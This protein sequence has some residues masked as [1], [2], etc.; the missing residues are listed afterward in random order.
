MLGRRER[1]TGSDSETGEEVVDDGPER[2]LPLELDVHRSVKCEGGDDGE[3]EGRDNIDF[4]VEGAEGDR[5][6][7]L[8]LGEDLADVVV[9]DYG[10]VDGGVI[11]FGIG[12]NEGIVRVGL[13]RLSAGLREVGVSH[14]KRCAGG[15]SGRSECG[16]RHR[17]ERIRWGRG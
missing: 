7:G 15:E 9:L 17:N 13:D 2:R 11:S 14:A 5:G 6:E 4:A 10:F 3:G 1:R 8:L 16:G 12:S